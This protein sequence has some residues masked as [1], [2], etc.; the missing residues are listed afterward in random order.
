MAKKLKTYRVYFDQINADYIEV[1][2]KDETAAS[3]TGHRRYKRDYVCPNIRS[4]EEVK[5]DN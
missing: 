4:I 1:K 3:I 5:V 2:A